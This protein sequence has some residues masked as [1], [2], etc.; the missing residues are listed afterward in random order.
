MIVLIGGPPR[1][2]KTR[3]ARLVCARDAIPFA[4]TDAIREVVNVAEPD[5]GRMPWRDLDAARVHA[6]RFFPFLDAFVSEYDMPDGRSILVE[7]VEFLPKHAEQLA[8]KRSARCCFLGLSECSVE[9]LEVAT[10]GNWIWD[11][12]PADRPGI[13][14]DIVELSLWLEHEC[15]RLGLPFV[16]RVGDDAAALERAYGILM[17]A[18]V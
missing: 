1:V 4:S 6:D 2:G 3:L 13:A 14:A 12:P 16:D 7:G 17:D 9:A 10:A 5:F 11:V 15:A 8:K 18:A